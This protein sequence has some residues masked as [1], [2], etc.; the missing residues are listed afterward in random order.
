MSCMSLTE[1]S[2]SWGRDHGLAHFSRALGSN[3]SFVFFFNLAIWNAV[4]SNVVFVWCGRWTVWWENNKCIAVMAGVLFHEWLSSEVFHSNGRIL[5]LLPFSALWRDLLPKRDFPAFL[6][7][8]ADSHWFLP[9][10][11]ELPF[12]ESLLA[13]GILCI[14]CSLFSTSSSCVVVGCFSFCPP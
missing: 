1:I 7:F 12:T 14:E 11:L 9:L 3:K 2:S 4:W 13:P 5:S 8:D 10:T 6:S